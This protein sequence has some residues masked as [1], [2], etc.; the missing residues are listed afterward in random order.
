MAPPNSARDDLTTVEFI[1]PEWIERVLGCTNNCA[2]PDLSAER[3]RIQFEHPSSPSGSSVR[4]F[5]TWDAGR[6]IEWHRGSGDPFDILVSCDL[7]VA[8]Y[9]F[10]G[11]RSPGRQIRIRGQNTDWIGLLPSALDLRTHLELLNPIVGLNFDLAISIS[12]YPLGPVQGQFSFVNG[13]PIAD[14][15]EFGTWRYETPTHEFQSLSSSGNYFLDLDL[16]FAGGISF[17]LGAIPFPEIAERS[18]LR[19]DY[20]VLGCLAGVIGAPQIVVGRR[21]THSVITMA[22]NAMALNQALLG[23]LRAVIDHP[24]Q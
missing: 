10:L 3:L 4:H 11:Q 12:D 2:F 18:V 16:P 19:G 22:T 24:S 1:S 17:L 15:S 20:L 7:D 9:L 6:L 23:T 5:Q 13:H 21:P 8:A 14:V